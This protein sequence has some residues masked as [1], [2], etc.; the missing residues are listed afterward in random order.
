MSIKSNRVLASYFNRFGATGKDAMDPGGLAAKIYVD[1]V[2]STDLW[3]GVPGGSA[4]ITNNIDIS[5]EGGMVWVKNRQSGS[6]H[7]VYDT[8]RG[9]GKAVRTDDT[10]AEATH[11][12]GPASFT[13]TG[14]TTGSSGASN[15]AGWTFRK[16]PGFFDIVTYE[17]DGSAQTITHNL[18]C[19]PGCIL[20]KDIDSVTNWEVYHK[21]TDT[22]A[23]QDYKIELNT[24]TARDDNANAWNDTAPTSSVFTVGVNNS[25]SGKTYIAYLFADGDDSAAQVFGDGRNESIIKCGTYEGSNTTSNVITVGFEPQ[26]LLIKNIDAASQWMQ[27]DTVRGIPDGTG[28]AYFHPSDID[29]ENTSFDFVDIKATG[30]ELKSNDNVTNASHTYIYVAIRKEA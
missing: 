13:S 27:F 9:A 19:V 25:T 6:A 22:S 20:V 21:H 2:F 26:Y 18:G 7:L 12:D 11:T 24:T 10:D 15:H 5:G 3:V 28:D 30:F 8:I 23:P 29:A 4:T 14:Y 17:G 1:D 16:A